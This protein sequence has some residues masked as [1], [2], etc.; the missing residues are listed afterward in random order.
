MCALTPHVAHVSLQLHKNSLSLQAHIECLACLQHRFQARLLETLDMLKAP[1][2]VSRPVCLC[3][4]DACK[5][6]YVLLQVDL[7]QASNLS[8]FGFP[9][10]TVPSAR[11]FLPGLN[12]VHIF[13]YV[14]CRVSRCQIVQ[15][16]IAVQALL[17]CICSA[18]GFLCR[19]L[20]DDQARG[21]QMKEP[22]PDHVFIQAFNLVR[23]DQADPVA[24]Q[25]SQRVYA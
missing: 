17:F 22:Y 24:S 23:V 10:D 15:S 19:V 12:E 4:V 3:S 6:A 7:V 16:N 1:T 9:E 14:V 2:D 5:H 11:S 18:K 21:K 13:Q 25:T 20:P 8:W